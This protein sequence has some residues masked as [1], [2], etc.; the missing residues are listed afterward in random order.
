V[1]CT[2]CVY[3]F[4]GFDLGYVG[5]VVEDCGSCYYV[6]YREGQQYPSECWEKGSVKVFESLK[7][8][9][10]YLLGDAASGLEVREFLET[11]REKFP[12]R[13]RQEAGRYAV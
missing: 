10:E 13:F 11:V 2:W 6:Q 4:G 8:C 1:I 12:N 5:L 9:Q 3:S 7:E